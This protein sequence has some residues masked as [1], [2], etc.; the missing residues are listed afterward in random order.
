MKVVTSC[1]SRFFI[2][3]LS[4]QLY[5]HNALYKIIA[6]YPYSSLKLFGIPRKNT[7][8]LPVIGALIRSIYALTSFLGYNVYPSNL[9]KI[10]HELYGLLLSK[11][12]P[13]DADV[14]IVLSSF[15]NE[16]IK[17]CSKYG[18]KLIVEHAS[19]HLKYDT[20]H[21]DNEYARWGLTP[22]SANTPLWCVEREQR[23]FQSCTTIVVPSKLAK[24]SLVSSGICPNKIRVNPLAVDVNLFRPIQTDDQPITFSILNVGSITIRK[25]ILGLMWAFNEAKLVD[26]SLTFV[27][28]GYE[29]ISRSEIFN[30]LKSENINFIGSINQRYLPQIYSQSSIFI[31]PSVSDGFGLVAL[32]AMSCGIPVIVSDKCGVSEC[33]VDGKTGFI[34][35]SGNYEKLSQLLNYCSNNMDEMKYMGKKA[36][37]EVL[38][39]YTWSQYGNRYMQILSK[40]LH[41]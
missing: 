23:E 41:Q 18:V 9:N 22:P 30:Q 17:K 5:Q 2:F 1:R 11:L 35:Q 21:V 24:E 3:E 20:I 10:I 38:E 19:L 16:S 28:S 37:E 26:A 8:P 15:A 25:G 31:M 4:R 12:L 36:R 39:K 40:S 14:F 34:Y 6:D 33:V 32:Q 27:G 29:N 13:K 7:Q